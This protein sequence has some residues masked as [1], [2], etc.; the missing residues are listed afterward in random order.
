MSTQ[1]VGRRSEYDTLSGALNSAHERGIASCQIVR[2]E[3]GS[4]KSRLVTEVLAAHEAVTLLVGFRPALEVGGSPTVRALARA[5]RDPFLS[6][7]PALGVT[8]EHLATKSEATLITPAWGREPAAVLAQLVD[9]ASAQRPVVLCLED[10][11]WAE[12]GE[13]MR[14]LDA[15]ASLLG[16][17]ESTHD[18][19]S[20]L[21]VLITLRPLEL[22]E[23]VAGLLRELAFSRA[24]NKTIDLGPL[25]ELEID[26]VVRGIADLRPS[27]PLLERI[28]Q[29][30]RGLPLLV[31]DAARR[32]RDAD[33]DSDAVQAALLPSSASAWARSLIDT[34]D[35]ADQPI[36]LHAALLDEVDVDVIAW[37]ADRTESQ[38]LDALDRACRSGVMEAADDGTRFTHPS[39]IE[40]LRSRTSTER[41]Q[42]RHVAIAEAFATLG[43]ESGRAA[44]LLSAG[45]LAGR[46][47]GAGAV[48][49]TAMEGTLRSSDNRLAAQYAEAALVVDPDRDIAAAHLVAALGHFRDYS[50]ERTEHH[51]ERAEDAARSGGD[52]ASLAKVLA[53]RNRL[54]LGTDMAPASFT[55]S[56]DLL[57]EQPDIEHALVAQ[58]C[59]DLSEYSTLSG[60]VGE[61]ERWALEA[62]HHAEL[63]DSFMARS[64]ASFALGMNLWTRLQL[65]AAL[66]AFEASRRHGDAAEDPWFR[67]WGRGRMP[68]VHLM[69]G[70]PTLASTAAAEAEQVAVEVG[71]QSERALALGTRISAAATRGRFDEVDSL[72]S[73]AIGLLRRT[74]YAW[75]ISFVMRPVAWRHAVVGNLDRALEIVDIWQEL[76][77]VPSSVRPYLAQLAGG[78]AVFVDRGWRHPLNPLTL[79]HAVWT[80]DALA[81]SEAPSHANLTTLLQ[82]AVSLNVLAGPDTGHLVAR[83]LAKLHKIGGDLTA[84]AEMADYA[85]EI[86]ER[87]DMPIETALAAL[88]GAEAR[89]DSDPS[90][91]IPLLELAAS[92][93]HE[94]GLRPT[95]ERT[96]RMAS[97]LGV[98]LKAEP[99]VAVTRTLLFTDLVGSTAMTSDVGD[100]TWVEVMG[101]HDAAIRGCLRS[102]FGHQFTHTGDGIGAWFARPADAVAAASE[103]ND[104]IDRIGTQFQLPLAVRSG[105]VI[106]TVMQRDS[107]LSGLD[108]ARATRVMSCA[109]AREVV[110]DAAVAAELSDQVVIDLGEVNLKGISEP[111]R[112]SRIGS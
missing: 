24:S 54:A 81:D 17:D 91:A 66:D 21:T 79:G 9:E 43:N 52:D 35:P 25:N 28:Q 7:L 36:M 68:I 40:L 39:L 3:A 106:G 77:R 14:L 56:R 86:A 83:A 90:A 70:H 95:Q 105:I 85:L 96:E 22:G 37:A 112:L 74:E 61:G 19:R 48:F 31:E 59:E 55:R 62:L 110:V 73:T 82:E 72:T 13:A 89:E 11:H 107:G 71:D 20:E 5:T 15:L 78:P 26:Q 18:R 49:R 80:A 111:Q 102:N 93:A 8:V 16:P 98:R 42:R 92:L 6:S 10:L 45:P 60:D 32:I 76:Q 69:E 50:P 46:V 65:G 97:R 108:V 38:V 1:F 44:H 57:A 99:P 29:S 2:G 4:G 63:A 33:G 30:T 104:A 23:P 53:L 88:A 109:G 75:A 103:I 34:V 101:A 67:C 100:A 41:R 27:G 64:V 12:Q 58:L 51:L 84:S 87:S 94:Y 47:D